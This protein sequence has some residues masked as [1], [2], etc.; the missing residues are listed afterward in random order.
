MEQLFSEMTNRGQAKV[1]KRDD[2]EDKKDESVH[3]A[4]IMDTYALMVHSTS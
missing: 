1:I 2:K 4:N 3:H